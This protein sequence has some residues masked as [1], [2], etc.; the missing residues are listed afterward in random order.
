MMLKWPIASRG[1]CGP[2][3]SGGNRSAVEVSWAGSPEAQDA[4]PLTGTFPEMVTVLPRGADEGDTVMLDAADT[5][6]ASKTAATDVSAKAAATRAAPT[7]AAVRRVRADRH[8]AVSP[9]L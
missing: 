2:N 4:V 7:R 6:E 9:S 8:M 5:A 1:A 3:P